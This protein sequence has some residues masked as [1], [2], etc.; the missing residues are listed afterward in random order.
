VIFVFLELNFILFDL[1]ED[2]VAPIF[3]FSADFSSSLL[4]SKDYLKSSSFPR[5]LLFR[6]LDAEIV[7]KMLSFLRFI[8]S[9][10]I[11]KFQIKGCFLSITES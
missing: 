10:A 3:F 11:C 8:F 9:L 2:D 7:E 6:N 4:F 1:D 5:M